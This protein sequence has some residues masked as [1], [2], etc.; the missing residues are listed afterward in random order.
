MVEPD[1]RV[2]AGGE[3][4]RRTSQMTRAK[5]D[6]KRGSTVSLGR[7][8]KS[9]PLPPTALG[10]VRPTAFAAS[11]L[12]AHPF[13]AAIPSRLAFPGSRRSRPK[14][15]SG[16]DRDCPSR[17]SPKPT[18]LDDDSPPADGSFFEFESPLFC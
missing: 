9:D 16:S 7:G 1:R 8:A 5:G 2:G 3:G 17:P 6:E 10:I 4:D 18:R 13:R 11:W 15:S 12:F 14:L